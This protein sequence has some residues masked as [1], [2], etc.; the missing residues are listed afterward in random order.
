VAA[1]APYLDMAY[2]LAVY[3]GRPVL[4]LSAGKATWPG[5]KQVWRRHHADGWLDDCLGVVDEPGP[6]DAE[7]LLVP[8]MRAGRRLLSEPLTVS[9]ARARR[10]IARLPAAG[11]H[12]SNPVRPVVRVSERLTRQRDETVA[13]IQAAPWEGGAQPE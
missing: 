6:L 11:R 1:D 4:K 10:E 7:P 3:A 13:T 8:V 9:R 2:K 5:A 12:W